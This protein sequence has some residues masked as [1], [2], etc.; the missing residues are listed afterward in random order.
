MIGLPTEKVLRTIQS[1]SK[2]AS[3]GPTPVFTPVHV[4]RALLCIGDEGPIG[5]IELSRKLGVGEGAVRTIIRHLVRAKVVATERGGCVLTARGSA[6]YKTLR[7]KLSK[8][9]VINGRQLAL[10]KWSV[11]VLV[12]GSGGLVKRGIEQR[13]AAIRAGATGACT[14]ICRN[15]KLV[16]PMGEDEEWIL[17]SNELLFQEIQQALTP[18]NNDV[19]T[20]V[21]A[22]AR[23]IAEYCAVAA[24]LTLVS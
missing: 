21:S 23:E 9:C 19:I 1:L 3:P 12:K 14:L 18:G 22:S 24:A 10:D 8:P 11:A 5:R 15:G 4:S 13:D 16:M 20:I 17:A 7:L 6:L 2:V